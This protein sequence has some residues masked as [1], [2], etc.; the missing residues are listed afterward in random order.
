M[1]QL[2][3]NMAVQPA[4]R[5]TLLPQLEFLQQIIDPQINK[6]KHLRKEKKKESKSEL[7]WSEISAS[8]VSIFFVLMLDLARFFRTDA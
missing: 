7:I 2:E 6:L 4:K 8:E 1:P 3:Q 5:G